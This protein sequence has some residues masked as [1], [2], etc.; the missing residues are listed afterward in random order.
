MFCPKIR[1]FI[2]THSS[3][4]CE[5]G[6][7][8]VVNIPFPMQNN[9][10][11]SWKIAF[12]LRVFCCLFMFAFFILSKT[13]TL[14]APCYFFVLKYAFKFRVIFFCLSLVLCFRAVKPISRRSGQN[15]L[16]RWQ[17]GRVPRNFSSQSWYFL[18]DDHKYLNSY[19]LIQSSSHH[20][21]SL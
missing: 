14:C 13:N 10:Q 17:T 21:I 11:F 12:K 2:F 18:S 7:F 19:C 1:V 15:V 5:I 9:S 16:L 3:H 20:H 8:L 4:Q 6:L